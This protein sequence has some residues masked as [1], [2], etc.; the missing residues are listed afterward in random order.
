MSSTALIIDIRKSRKM[1]AEARMQ[2]QLRLR[3][4]INALDPVFAPYLQYKLEF[5]GGDGVEGVFC[6]AAAAYL[7]CRLFMLLVYP[8]SVRCGLGLGTI[9]VCIDN[10]KTNAQD[11][12]AF[13]RAR[14]CLE[15]G[16]KESDHSVLFCADNEQ[17]I[18]VNALLLCASLLH[19][20]HTA[21][22]HNYQLL[23]E[24]HS[25][26]V[27]DDQMAERFKTASPAFLKLASEHRKGKNP[28]P[29][30]DLEAF[31]PVI[32]NGFDLTSLTV[33]T[34]KHGLA[35]AA[36]K[37]SGVKPQNVQKIW[38][39]GSAVQIRDIE[40]AAVLMLRERYDFILS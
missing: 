30:T 6:T 8:V 3:D 27:F 10:E 13:H 31:M 7:Y 28:N 39:R 40:T 12:T 22:R 38:D 23:F 4:C 24:L 37:T 14:R 16:R 19:S 25:P 36:A 15:A 35:T 9:D 11:G 33:S 20:Q 2:A 5:S 32:L 29:L 18:I 1:T 17:D 21:V 26:I 34:R